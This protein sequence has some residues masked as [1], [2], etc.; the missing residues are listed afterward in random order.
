MESVLGPESICAF[1][2][3]ITPFQIDSYTDLINLVS[4]FFMESC[5][6]MQSPGFHMEAP[7]NIWSYFWMSRRSEMFHGSKNIHNSPWMQKQFFLW[8][9]SNMWKIPQPTPIM[10]SCHS[11]DIH[12]WGRITQTDFT[13]PLYTLNILWSPMP[14]KIFYS[15]LVFI[16]TCWQLP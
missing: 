10:H 9:P 3:R 13:T 5:W 6:H 4:F 1:L 8:P 12:I 15:P 16:H 7:K 11:S 2:Y 14:H